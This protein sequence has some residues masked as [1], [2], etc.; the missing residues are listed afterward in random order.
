MEETA[1]MWQV[2]EES[3]G[4]K[5]GISGS[6]LKM[7]AVLV[8]LLDHI[9]AVVLSR[10]I[11]GSGYIPA[12]LTGGAVYAEWVSVY[13]RLFQCYMIM[14]A[15]GRMGFPIFCFLLVEGFQKT[16]SV[17]KYGLRL[18]IFA[19]ISE[20]PFNL[21]LT[22]KVS[23]TGYQN[24]FMTLF[25]GFFAL[26]VY[27]FFESCMGTDK[28]ERVPRV[29]WR[30]LLGTGTVL[31]AIYFGI[32]LATQ[33]FETNRPVRDYLNGTVAF[34]LKFIVVC[35]AVCVA[36][37]V[38][39]WLCRTYY[40]KDEEGRDRVRVLSVDLTVLV[41]LMCLA[42]FLRTDYGG[43]GVLTITAMYVFRRNR[44]EEVTRARSM[45]VGCAVLAF[46]DVSEVFAFFA[47][48]PVAFY[49]GKR[50]LKIKYFFYVFYPVHLLLLYLIAVWLGVG[51]VAPL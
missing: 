16:R 35:V 33:I 47:L 21:A 45:A 44:M 34:P 31:P 18:L 5:R 32:W 19:V 12:R 15:I 14:R 17:K 22:G 28:L 42:D 40:E 43:S 20:I 48:I 23:A 3:S 50:G 51:D 37:G 38:F 39:Y 26:G 13:K 46:M 29:I 27:G 8:M 1:G 6:T 7:V 9:A 30:L 11:V 4:R 25:L 36:L 2:P 41:L 49:S 24:V 10:V